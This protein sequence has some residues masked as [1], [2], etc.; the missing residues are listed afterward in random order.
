MRKVIAFILKLAVVNTTLAVSSYATTFIGGA[1]ISG[2]PTLIGNNTNDARRMALLYSQ[3]TIPDDADSDGDGLSDSVETNTGVYVSATDTGTNPNNADSDGDGL[4]DGA[5][6]NTYGSNPNIIDADGD[7]V[8]DGLE[9]TEGTDPLDASSY[10]SFSTGLV[11]YYPFNGNANDESVYSNDG[12]IS[13]ATLTADR[14]GNAISAFD[15]DGVDDFISISDSSSL[16]IGSQSFSL[17]IWAKVVNDPTLPISSII[18][19]YRGS[20]PREFLA[21]EHVNQY[22]G[23]N[24]AWEFSTRDSNDQTIHL[25]S[26]D[27]SAVPGSW[28]HIVGVRDK[29]SKVTKLFVNGVL[30][31]SFTDERTGSFTGLSAGQY[32]IGAG[33]LWPQAL[34]P[35]GFFSGSLDDA[36]IYNR[37]LSSIEVSELFYSEA[38]QFQI[39]NGN[40]TWHEAKADA[41]S[42]GG[43]LAVLN[44]QAKI[45]VIDSYLSGLG[46]W[47]YLFIGLTDEEVEGDWRWITGE[48][49][50]IN[51][52]RPGEPAGDG[53]N[54]D[55]GII[56]GSE[57]NSLKYWLSTNG[58]SGSYILEISSNT[59]SDG[60][61][62]LD[63]VET[64]TGIY[65]SETDTGTDPNNADSDGDTLL[66]GVESNSG[67][68]VGL[69]DTGTNPNS[70]D[71]DADGFS[72][73]FEV[74]AGYDPTSSEDT[75]DSLV[76]IRTAVEL[77]IY[78]AIGGEYRIEYTDAIESDVWITAEEGIIGNGGIIRR[79]YNTREYSD[80][81]Y[82]AIR[83][84]Q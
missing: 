17:S 82:R 79:L 11:A 22:N 7:G 83:T 40:F 52:W 35:A 80:R 78:T 27:G 56:R 2:G 63:S 9:I 20:S 16:N 3:E 38:P 5:E 43:R 72:D 68:F 19:N 25:N 23:L 26:T 55:Y 32:W 8:S 46:S 28:V 39:I 18:S 64:N 71:S 65:V 44:T 30:V 49:L 41:E 59:D 51:N 4:D 14:F 66:D 34:T 58:N 75:P 13:G 62:L 77:D 50:T 74:Y 84:D 36:R 81:F 24:Q 45:D 1:Y 53:V 15:F 54:D 12:T 67:T 76:V 69:S 61:G 42:R 47:P 21:L 31:D 37:S 73:D 60:D 33:S 70:T 57:T 10:N 29:E 6:I 48:P